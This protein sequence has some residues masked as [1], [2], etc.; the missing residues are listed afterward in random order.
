MALF[1]IESPKSSQ[2]YK[3]LKAAAS[4]STGGQIRE[5][6]E[7]MWI[8]Y[9]PYADTDFR[10]SFAIDEDAGF[11]ELYLTLVMPQPGSMPFAFSTDA[12]AGAVSNF[13]NALAAS[14]SL[15]LEAIPAA[16]MVYNCNSVGNGPRSSTPR[17]DTSSLA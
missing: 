7:A 17:T 10:E 4:D 14:G 6:L 8:D 3:H 15:E 5:C 11:W 13:I 1:D 2:G 12:A 9:E 16:K